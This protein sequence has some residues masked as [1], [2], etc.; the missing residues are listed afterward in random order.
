MFE[1]CMESNGIHSVWAEERALKK[2]TAQKLVWP[3]KE[4]SLN[5]NIIC[6]RFNFHMVLLCYM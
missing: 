5:V 3:Y 1:K 6:P 2:V 4:F